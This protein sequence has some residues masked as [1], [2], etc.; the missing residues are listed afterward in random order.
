MQIRPKWKHSSSPEQR[1]CSS[2]KYASWW[3]QNITNEYFQEVTHHFHDGVQCNRLNRRRG[4]QEL[5][6]FIILKIPFFHI[7]FDFLGHT[8]YSSYSSCSQLSQHGSLWFLAVSQ[9]EY[10]AEKNLIWDTSRHYAKHDD[11]AILHSQRGPPKMLQTML[12]LLGQVCAVPR[13]ILWRRLGFQTSMWQQ[14]I[15]F[16]PAKCSILFFN[17]PCTFFINNIFLKGYILL[18]NTIREQNP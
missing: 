4:L 15:T 7:W 11:P 9:A 14:L 5:G 16:S 2:H 18:Y 10:S 8:Q 12:G 17:R 1:T 13:R 6:S 3:C